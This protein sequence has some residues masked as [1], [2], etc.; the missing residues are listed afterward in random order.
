MA[1][2]EACKLVLSVDSSP[3]THTTLSIV[4]DAGVVTSIAVASKLPAGG[5]NA[6]VVVQ[7][8]SVVGL[9]VGLGVGSGVGSGVT[10]GVGLK[11]G[12]V[13]DMVGLVIGLVVGFDVGLVVGFD[14]GLVV[15]L[16]EG[17]DVG[18]LGD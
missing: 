18:A 3:A 15:G 12:L 8:T 4:T 2:N 7:S 11:V 17:L 9:S 14:D 10:S 6:S 16:D 5:V 1:C 13:V